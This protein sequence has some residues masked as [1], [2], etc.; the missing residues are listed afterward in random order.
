MFFCFITDIYHNHFCSLG[1]GTF[2][3]LI[4]NTTSEGMLSPQQVVRLY[5]KQPPLSCHQVAIQADPPKWWPGWTHKAEAQDASEGTAEAK[6]AF[7]HQVSHCVTVRAKQVHFFIGWY[8]Q[9]YNPDQS[10]SWHKQESFWVPTCPT[11]PCPALPAA[12]ELWPL[13]CGD[14]QQ[15][16]AP[17]MGETGDF[18]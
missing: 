16:L 14:A 18:W 8:L 12:A 11:S 9:C 10:K 4:H 13:P 7:T 17:R 15:S 5:S 1:I 6:W 2:C 3:G